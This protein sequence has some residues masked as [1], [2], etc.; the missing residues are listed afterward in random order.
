MNDFNEELEQWK[1][2]AK[3]T[4]VTIQ[5]PELKPIP[6]PKLA[7]IGKLLE[8]STG[9][10]IVIYDSREERSGRPT[11]LVAAFDAWKI[12]CKFIPVV[13][14]IGDYIVNGAC[15]EY[16]TEED[17]IQ[18][19]ISGHLDEQ[20][21]N[22]SAR[23][24]KSYLFVEGDIFVQGE[25]RVHY[26]ALLS[27][28]LGASFKQS[29]HGQHGMINLVPLENDACFPY[30]VKFLMDKEHIRY[31]PPLKVPVNKREMA[32]A[33]LR[34]IPSVGEGRARALIQHFKSLKSVFG[35]SVDELTDVKDVGKKTA[36]S[37]VEYIDRKYKEKEKHVL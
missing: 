23:Y 22:M 1:E 28:F 12:E 29:S 24:D 13:L 5:E 16:K 11:M 20:L 18:S 37:I 15:I 7:A 8:L 9:R 33:T 36:E 26:N 21:F 19:K 14:P 31:P 27:S 3:A 6:Q 17:F 35:A 32:V 25:G 10:N 34:T 30:A 2:S 4:K